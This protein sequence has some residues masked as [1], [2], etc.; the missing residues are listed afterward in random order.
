M[1]RILPIL[2]IVAFGSPAFAQA[3]DAQGA[4]ALSETLT[5]YV[6]KAA[7]DKG[8]V[9]IAP[10][11]DAYRLAL[12]FKALVNLFPKQDVVTFDVSPYA[13]KVKPATGGSWQ[14]E[15][16][17]FPDGWFEVSEPA[18][19][20]MQWTTSGGTFSGVFDPEIATFSSATGSYTSIR[21]LTEDAAGK[22]D[23]TYGP[24]S[25]SI[26]ATRTTNGG[27]DF[28]SKYDLGKYAENRSF[29][30]P[31][32]NTN[33]PIQASAGSFVVDGTGKGLKYKTLLD[34]LAFGVAHP[35]P[36]LVKASQG[37]LKSLLAAALP[38]W[39][40]ID[41]SYTIS[42]LAVTTPAGIFRAGKLDLAV[43]MDGVRQ[44][45]KLE[46]NFR[47]G[48]IELASLFL[49]AWAPA[50]IPTELDL[51]FSGTNL[52]LDVPARKLIDALDVNQE[53]PVPVAVTDEIAAT[54]MADPPKLVLSR[55]TIRNAD[56]EIS[57]EG[58]MTFTGGKPVMNATI[59]AAGFDKAVATLQAAAPTDQQVAEMLPAL[60]MV[61]GFG[62]AL[63]DGRLQWAV[64]VRADGS[65][66]VN[67]T[68]I[69]PADPVPTPAP[70]QTPAPQ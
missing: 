23:A 44:D 41:G 70:P 12:D 57:A 31:N 48:G 30:D 64:N 42:D 34:L 63:P 67:G 24:G 13:L 43:A 36:D 18:R 21:L 9:K 27:F 52:D 17:L 22:G 35:E 32:T 20:R 19:Q 3:V 58:E 55:S 62:K 47:I 15:G 39:D 25:L 10:D 14:V 60:A 33:F 29:A 2:S 28:T 16:P 26:T 5:R 45:G 37:E 66:F 51:N 40:H 69:K 53:P 46:Y 65:V 1:R 59:E 7:F 68:M 8:I 49:P 4:T 56:T 54:F 61:K 6:G 11:G 50:L 38:L